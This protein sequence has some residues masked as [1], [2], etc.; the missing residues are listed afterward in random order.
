MLNQVDT[1]YFD[2]EEVSFANI[3]KF[4]IFWVKV[5]IITTN[6]ISVF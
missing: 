6:N 5:L 3:S 2:V 1:V 4:L